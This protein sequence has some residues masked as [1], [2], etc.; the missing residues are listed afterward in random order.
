MIVMTEKKIPIP[1]GVTVSMEGRKITVKGPKGSLDRDFSDPRYDNAMSMTVEGNEFVV[2]SESDKKKI[3]SVV[4]T[5]AAHVKNLMDG[6]KSGY[7]YSMKIYYTHFPIT[8]EVKGQTVFAK[9]L[10]GEKSM[11]KSEIYKG[12]KVEIKKDDVTLTGIDKDAVAQS[13]ANIESSCKLS[14]KDRRVFLDGIYITKKA[15]AMDA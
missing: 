8:L 6:V 11:R 9:N 7:K 13:A 14:K 4:G 12:V 1:E 2:K 5:F 10:L 3:R 15:E